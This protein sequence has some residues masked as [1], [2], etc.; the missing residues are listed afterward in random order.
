MK[1][2][3]C[4]GEGGYDEIIDPFLGGP[5]YRCGYCQGRG[6]VGV[7]KWLKVRL[8]QLVYPRRWLCMKPPGRAGHTRGRLW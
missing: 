6:V 7:W 8:N 5:Y 3:M 2:P 4:D 1:C